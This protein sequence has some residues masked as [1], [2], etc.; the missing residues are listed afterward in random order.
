MAVFWLCWIHI[1]ECQ[2]GNQQELGRVIIGFQ[3]FGS[4]KGNAYDRL[5]ILL[6]NYLRNGY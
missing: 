4:R 3:Y 6:M 2:Y 5:R 1:T